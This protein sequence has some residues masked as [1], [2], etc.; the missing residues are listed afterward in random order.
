M[1]AARPDLVSLPYYVYDASK[2]T[3]E[4]FMRAHDY[5]RSSNSIINPRLDDALQLVLQA[6]PLE[7]TQLRN[8]LYGH[9]LMETVLQWAREQHQ[10]QGN[11]LRFEK[12]CSLLRKWRRRWHPDT[13]EDP[14]DPNHE[15]ALS[16]WVQLKAQCSVTSA[17][18][19]HPRC[20]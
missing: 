1:R 14:D 16:E 3:M 7:E 15:R 10:T 12:A 11:Q 18:R 20:I 19:T 2:S 8:L 17:R 9:L 6:F 4:N 5:I 13:G